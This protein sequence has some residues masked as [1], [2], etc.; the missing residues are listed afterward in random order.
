MKEERPTLL[1]AEYLDA[2]LHVAEMGMLGQEAVAYSLFIPE[3]Y[4]FAVA[5]SPA[6]R[7]SGLWCSHE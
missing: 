4:L 7:T 6:A 1:T 5:D 3:Q 2:L